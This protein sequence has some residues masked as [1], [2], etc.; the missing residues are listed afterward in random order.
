MSAGQ[1][2]DARY[3]KSVRCVP[4][5]PN[6]AEAAEDEPVGMARIISV[7]MVPIERRPA[8]PVVESRKYRARLRS[9]QDLFSDGKTQYERRFGEPFIGPIIPFGS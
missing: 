1:R 4:W 6:P 2:G 5:Q 3:A 9:V 7:P 8:V